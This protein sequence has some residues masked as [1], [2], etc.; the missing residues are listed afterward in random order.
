MI[1]R[2][3]KT[4]DD[5]VNNSG[6]SIS[7]SSVSIPLRAEYTSTSQSVSASVPCNVLLI[8]TYLPGKLGRQKKDAPFPWGTL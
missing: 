1:S 6:Y 7:K 2:P 5:R 4:N 8:V 3:I